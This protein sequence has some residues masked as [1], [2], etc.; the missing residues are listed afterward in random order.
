MARRSRPPVTQDSTEADMSSGMDKRIQLALV[1]GAPAGGADLPRALRHP[2]TLPADGPP[3]RLAG[4]HRPAP[5]GDGPSPFRQ[6]SNGVARRRHTSDGDGTG[7][8][9]CA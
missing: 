9:W 8:G 4:V 1:S 7:G 3:S 6:P 2:S 5:D